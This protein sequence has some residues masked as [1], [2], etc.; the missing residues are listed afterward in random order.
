MDTKISE[1]I[2]LAG[3]LGTR[4][5]PVVADVPKCMAIVNGKPFIEYIIQYLISQNIEKIILSLGYKSEQIIKFVNSKFP[6]SLFLFSIEKEPLGTGGAIQLA[7]TKTS[8]TNIFIINGDTY[9][10]VD[11]NSLASFHLSNNADCTLCLKEMQNFDR[12]GVVELNHKNQIVSFKE[13]Q[14]YTKGL[15]NAGIYALNIASFKKLQLQD[16]FSFEKD[17]LEKYY[18]SLAFYGNKQESYFIDIGIPEDFNKA[19]QDF[20]KL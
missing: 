20:K 6:N 2:I 1:A 10:S 7:L 11:L 14:F 18:Q 3:G 17:F 12:Y 16:K 19:Q 4:L 9:F 13:K 15:I 5:R 8:S